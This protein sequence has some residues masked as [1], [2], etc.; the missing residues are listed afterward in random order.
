MP[1]RLGK[2]NDTL[3]EY[4]IIGQDISYE[5][6]QT[7]ARSI[8]KNLQS[9]QFPEKA[10]IKY[11][12]DFMTEAIY[13]SLILKLN[14]R[15]SVHEGLLTFGEPYS[16]Y[17]T[18]CLFDFYG[19]TNPSSTHKISI[20]DS[21]TTPIPTDSWIELNNIY[22]GKIGAYDTNDIDL[23]Y[24]T[25][26]YFLLE[27][28]LSDFLTQFS[29]EEIKRFTLLYYGMKAAPVKIYAWNLIEGAWYLLKT[30]NYLD[31]T[32]FSVP[33]FYQ[34]YQIA[35]QLYLPWGCTDF[36]TYFINTADSNRIKFL[37]QFPENAN[38]YAQYIRLAVNG[39]LAIPTRPEDL[40]FRESFIGAG[41]KGSVGLQ[42]V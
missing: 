20:I 7:M 19:I 33:A 23:G 41:R 21:A 26:P 4:D 37:V 42:E 8:E 27:F 34:N 30:A 14:D 22:Y 31:D 36:L 17:L 11:D 15:S 25:N 35:A 5:K 24:G 18:K 40:N 1:M 16:E 32:Q 28:K 6:F 13:R 9:Y 2:A 29:Y 12:F 3:T 39:F 10:M 38:A